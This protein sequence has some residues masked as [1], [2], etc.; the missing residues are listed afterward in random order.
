MHI[1][2]NEKLNG[3]IQWLNIFIGKSILI[4]ISDAGLQS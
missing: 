2:Y 3:Y 4:G 1:N